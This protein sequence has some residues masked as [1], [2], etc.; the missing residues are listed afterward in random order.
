ME[1]REKWMVSPAIGGKVAVS[2]RL[3]NDRPGDAIIILDNEDTAWEFID[4]G[5]AD[6]LERKKRKR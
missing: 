5:R 6:E 3:K 4:S 1:K 2:Y